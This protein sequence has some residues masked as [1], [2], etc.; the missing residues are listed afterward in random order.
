MKVELQLATTIFSELFRV[1][2]SSS[3]FYSLTYLGLKKFLANQKSQEVSHEKDAGL[4]NYR[5]THK[6]V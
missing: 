6:A 3:I 4:T 2:G 1:L 5:L